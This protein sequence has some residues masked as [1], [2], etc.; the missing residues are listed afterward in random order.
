MPQS[1]P[2]VSPSHTDWTE[3]A[4]GFA[5]RLYNTAAR[6]GE[7]FIRSFVLSRKQSIRDVDVTGKRVFVRVDF[8]VPI[9]GGV[10]TD[11][12]RIRA[13]IPT[14]RYLLDHGASV[15]LASHLGR[16]KGSVRDDLRLAPVAMRLSEILQLPVRVAPDS[17]GP[18]TEA[19]ARAL[20]PGELL[21]LE[22]VRFHPEEEANDPNYARGLARL[23]DI[24]VNDAFG[25]AHR[26][27]ASTEGITHYL[28]SVAGLLME[29]EL[30]ALG[31][32]INQPDRPL[33]AIIGG[34]KIS[35]KIGVLTHLL[36]VADAFLIGGGMAN[37]LL[38]AQGTD[39]GA[40]LVEEDKL[41]DAR[42]FLAAAQAQG[43]HV[44]LPQD[45]VVVRDLSADAPSRTI[46]VEDVSDDWK[47]VDIGPETV[48]AFGNLVDNAG[49]I[50]WNGP[51]GIFELPPFATGTRAVA[52]ALARSRAKTIVGGG[53]SVA[54]VEQ[55]G[56]A[57][58]MSHIST[59]GGASLEFLEG[60]TLPG[61]AALQETRG[62]A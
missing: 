11:D 1:G 58:Q 42:S 40:S 44:A 23:A 18:E 29:S 14:I 43:R 19:L 46:A 35:S 28:P 57:P 15:V 33:V 34:A 41:D 2:N 49:T 4:H 31:S 55:A 32:A 51:M 10:I 47:I 22:N 8:N 48:S 26:A 27:H 45:V 30:A 62:G 13:A 5:M 9:H 39:V 37:T 20:Q 53:D 21:M 36:G 59:G 24:Y 6:M 60:R 56:L 3:P 52:Q 16:P 38:K 50:V 25:S 7:L 61:V 17:V 54:A 12:T